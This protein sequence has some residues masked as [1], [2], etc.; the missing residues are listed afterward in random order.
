MTWW[1]YFGARRPP[2]PRDPAPEA[3][4]PAPAVA[5][6]QAR[7]DYVLAE[8]GL[9]VITG[10]SGLGKTTLVRTLLTRLHP[11][12]Y[13]AIY[14][15]VGE[16]WTVRTL[17]RQLAYELHLPVPFRPLETE[18]GVREA[19]WAESTQQGRL[20]VLVLDE[21]HWLTP[22]V[23]QGLRRV[24]NFA[25]DTTAPL[26]LL[27]VGHT[28]LRRKL[29]LQPLEALRDRVTMAFHL[30]PF[31][32]AETA[33]YLQHQLRHVGIDRPVFTETALH[34]AQ[35]WAQGRPRRINTW[36][37]ACLLA[38]FVAQQPIVDDGVV[39]TAQAELQ[40]TH[41]VARV[42]EGGHTS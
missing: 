6:C 15:A 24:V 32:A 1:E 25:M 2:F 22:A 11:T 35:D 29:A 30:P 12:H 20:P 4:F 9:W 17:Y 38:A 31:T 37:R 21:A 40:W 13:H 3:V 7:L 14:M 27:L 19:L 42:E 10:E 18:R 36:A 28:E 41:P 23:L 26:A 34:A 33:D 16:D 8:R 5:E 39:A